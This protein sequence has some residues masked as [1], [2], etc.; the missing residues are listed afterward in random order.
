MRYTCID[1]FSG[2]GGLSLGL[3]KAGFEILFSFDID[4]LSIKTQNL[5]TKYF[6]HEAICADITQL[7]S[8]H[9]MKQLGIKRGELTLFAGG[10][11]CQG[12]SIQRIGEDSDERN[13]LVF[14]FMKK[15]VD[16][17]PRFFLIFATYK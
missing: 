10:P 4:E 9:L 1:S 8:K 16:F 13:N 17:F 2:A 7:N 12:F 5:N 3:S 15:V 14:E 6:N 11:P